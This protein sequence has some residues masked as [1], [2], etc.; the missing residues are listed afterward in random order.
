M[1][2]KKDLKKKQKCSPEIEKAA[3]I[4]THYGFVAL[5]ETNVEKEDINHAKKFHESHLKILHPFKEKVNRFSGYLEEKISLLRHFLNK[6]YIDLPQPVTAFYTGPLKGNP[7]IKEHTDDESFNLEIIGSNKSI[8]DATI[9][10]TTLIILK[11]RYPGDTFSVEINTIGD[12]DA[13]VKFAKELSGFIKKESHKLNK[14]CKELIKK[15][16][17]NLFSCNHATCIDIQQRAPKSLTYLSESSRTHFKE[18]LEYLESLNIQYS[19]NHSLIGSRSYCTD[20]IFEIYST[21]KNGTTSIVAMGERYNHLAKKIW[22]KREIPAIGVS[23]YIHP[24][25][26]T[27][28]PKKIE[29]KQD[30]K[31][32]FIQFG[33]DAKL[34]SLALIEML[35]QAKIP[36]E[37]SLSKD[38]LSIQLA[39]AEKMNIPYIIIMGQKEAIEN[40]VVVRNLETRCQETVLI[41]ELTDYLKKLP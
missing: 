2:Q 30:A 13:S 34:K 10:E 19:I 36:I 26:V 33:F 8:S 37:Q 22:G 7:H 6:N 5:P 17:Y 24:H 38:K 31:F 41:S 21:K 23:I 16:I 4:A 28:L 1:K 39:T 15:D 9:I 18:V 3:T 27:K 32:F 35:R 25:F 14:S 20:T 12:K 40:S 11:D 29:K